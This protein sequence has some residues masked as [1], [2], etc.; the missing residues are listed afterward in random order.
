MTTHHCY[1]AHFIKRGAQTLPNFKK[2]ALHR[3]FDTDEI[4]CS[5]RC[6]RSRPPPTPDSPARIPTPASSDDGEDVFPS[7]VS[8]RF[9]RYT[10]SNGT[11]YCQIAGLVRLASQSRS[12]ASLPDGRSEAS[13]AS[14]NV[15]FS[16]IHNPLLLTDC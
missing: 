2:A 14:Q 10:P 11:A 9:L 1:A 5:F 6:P 8:V 4:Q 15:S 7:T 12:A 16:E 3:S 13:Q